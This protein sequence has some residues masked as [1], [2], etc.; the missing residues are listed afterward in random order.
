MSRKNSLEKIPQSAQTSRNQ[1]KGLN[2][3]DF[4]TKQNFQDKAPSTILFSDELNKLKS[5]E[6]CL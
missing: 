3:I 1:C 4:I 2:I 5:C 6:L